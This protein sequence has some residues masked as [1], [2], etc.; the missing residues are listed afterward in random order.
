MQENVAQPISSLSEKF[1][2]LSGDQL[3]AIIDKALLDARKSMIS[4]LDGEYIKRSEFEALK[5][6]IS[7]ISGRTSGLEAAQDELDAKMRGARKPG[8]KQTARI[9]KLEQILVARKNQPMTFSEVGKI[10]E[11]GSRTPSGKNTRRQNMT[12]LGKS[13]EGLSDKFEVFSS[14]TQ[15]GKMVRLTREYFQ[16]LMRVNRGV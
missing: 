14:K 16:H 15:C 6:R 8:Q 3:Q 7:N 11:L 10:L 12:L 5:D 13:L 1:F 9:A 2:I 4:E